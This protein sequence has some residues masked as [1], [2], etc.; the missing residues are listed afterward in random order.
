MA[1]LIIRT[2]ALVEQQAAYKATFL[3]P[4]SDVDVISTDEEIKF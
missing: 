3:L 2:G 1:D 4:D